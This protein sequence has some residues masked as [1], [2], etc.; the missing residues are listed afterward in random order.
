MTI[1]LKPETQQLLDRLMAAGH[2]SSVEDAIHYALS[3]VGTSDKDLDWDYINKALDE[4]EAQVAR[5]EFIEI[6]GEAELK[7]FFADVKRRG[8]NVLRNPV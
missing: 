4:A 5:G 3:A 2:F 6:S 8:S 1:T 7:A